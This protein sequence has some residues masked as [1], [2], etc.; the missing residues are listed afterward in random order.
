MQLIL[1]SPASK[2]TI[3]LCVRRALCHRVIFEIAGSADG[4]EAVSGRKLEEWADKTQVDNVLGKGTAGPYG[5]GML[6]RLEGFFIVNPYHGFDVRL[7]AHS[8]FVIAYSTK[9]AMLRNSSSGTRRSVLMPWPWTLTNRW[10]TG[11][12]LQAT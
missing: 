2:L 9:S 1:Q 7:L 12:A 6:G 11:L 3:L 8:P 10:M 4:T 5:N